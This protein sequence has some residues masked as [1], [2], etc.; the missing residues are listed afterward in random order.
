ME[1]KE[2]LRKVKRN[3]NAKLIFFLHLASYVIINALIV[4]INLITSPQYFWFKWPLLG[5]GVG[6]FFHA[7][8]ILVFYGKSSLKERMIKKEMEKEIEDINK[9]I[10]I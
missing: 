7:L 5:W 4:I 3:V 1:N 9:S 6:I 10:K 2:V 8:I